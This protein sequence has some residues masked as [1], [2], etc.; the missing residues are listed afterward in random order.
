MPLFR[1]PEAFALLSPLSELDFGTLSLLTYLGCFI[2]AA[3]GLSTLGTG[4]WSTSPAA[5]C[6]QGEK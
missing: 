1:K 2:Q 5:L 4:L 6:F 3:R